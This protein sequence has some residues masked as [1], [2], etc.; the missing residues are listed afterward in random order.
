MK[1][2]F[3]CHFFQQLIHIFRVFWIQLS[4]RYVEMK[5]FE[6]GT[7]LPEKAKITITPIILNSKFP[8]KITFFRINFWLNEEQKKL[9]KNDH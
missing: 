4:P 6:N 8:F 3:G 5:F 7:V 1:D 9:Y 2:R